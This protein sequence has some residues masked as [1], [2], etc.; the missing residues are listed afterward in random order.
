MLSLS[1]GG[2]VVLVIERRLLVILSRLK[3]PTF[4]AMKYIWHI[5]TS[6]S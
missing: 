1:H 5:L 4:G 6:K 3:T 2:V